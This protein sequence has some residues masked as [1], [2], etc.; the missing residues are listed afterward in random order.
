MQ[1]HSYALVIHIYHRNSLSFLI[2]SEVITVLHWH[3]I[4]CL[5]SMTFL[6]IHNFCFMC[7]SLQNKNPNFKQLCILN[8]CCVTFTGDSIS[9]YLRQKG[10]Q[11]TKAIILPE[12]SL[13]SQWVQQGLFAGTMATNSSYLS[14][15]SLHFHFYRKM[16]VVS[17]LR[18][19]HVSNHRQ[20]QLL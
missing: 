10:Q 15:K 11:Q 12:S 20:S 16:L 7:N 5:S 4:S 8:S 13:L 14:K 6:T 17:I 2:H 3:N 18:V 1:L 19:S 9:S